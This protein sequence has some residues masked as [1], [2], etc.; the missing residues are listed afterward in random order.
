MEA[1]ELLERVDIL[2]YISQYCDFEK[3]ND[4]EYW[5][6]SPLTDERTPSFSVN[7]EK[8]RFYDFSSGTGGNL[9]HFVEKYNRCGFLRATEILR[10]YAGIA[11][12][13]APA[14]RLSAV[15]VAK[16]FR[17]SPK[18]RKE[19]AASVLPDD[20]MNR[21]E[22]R[23]DKLRAWEQEGISLDTMKRFGV[24]Y[25]SFSDRIVFPLK[26]PAG[27]IINICGRTLDPNYKEKKLRKYTYF[28]P[29]GTLDTLYG[30]SDNREEILGKGEI[31]LFEGAKSVMIASEWG[32][33]NT[34]AILTS[35]LNDEQMLLLIRLGVRCVFALDEDV[36]VTQDEKIR[37]LRHYVRVEWAR[38]REHLLSPKMS[39]VD[40]GRDT[41]NILYER[42][43]TLS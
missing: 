11:E 19:S 27:K 16:R 36:D 20:V 9:I 34:A 6:C 38:N 5:A 43:E 28:K 33:R 13:T 37:K 39:P 12:D 22:F 41:W 21:Y 25:D 14:V 40:A 3:R 4:G 23:R 18:H 7:T 42:R 24:R 32:V 35:H 30:L 15:N 1:E 2:S 31:I 8:Q 17:R 26:D 29:L 10:Q